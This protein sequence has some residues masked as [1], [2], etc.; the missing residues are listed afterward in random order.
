[1]IFCL[2][3][4]AYAENPHSLLQVFYGEA[5]PLP[6]EGGIN[7]VRSVESFNKGWRFFLGDEQSAK[8][9]EYNDTKWRVLTLPHDWSIEGE[10]SKD[11]PATH[12]GGALPGGVGWYR[13]TFSLP[14]LYNDKLVFI[15]FDGVYRNSEVWINGHYLGLRPYGYSSFRYDITPYLKFGSEKNVIAVRADNSEQPNSRWY[16]GSGIYRNVWLVITNK[17]YVDH[18]GTFIATPEVT[19]ERAVV[20]IEVKVRNDLS[21]ERQLIIKTIILD[22]EGKKIAEVKSDCSAA[23]QSVST[24]T[25]N[26]EIENP[27]LWSTDIPYLY[28]AVTIIED[29]NKVYDNYETA[30]GV[31]TF[32]FNSTRGFFLNGK[33]LKIYGVCNH[34]D[35]GCLGAAVNTRAIERQLEIL[36][37]MGCNGIRTSHNLPAPE[38][39]DLCDKMGFIVMDEAFDMW[40]KKKTDYDYSQNWDEWH[41]RDLQDLILRDRNHPSVFLWSIGNEILEQWDSTGIAIAQELAAIVKDLDNTRPITSGSNEPKPH[42]FIIRSGVNDVIGFNYHQEDFPDLLK[43]Y[44]GQKFIASETTSALASRGEYNMPSDS[45]RVWPIRWDSVFTQGN[46]DNTCSAYDNCRVPWG[47][48]HEEAWRLIKSY[49][50]L[51]GMFIWTGFDYL[52]EP[53]PYV[54]PSRSSYFGIIDLAG[55]PKDAYYMYQSEWTDKNVLHILPHWNWNKGDTIDVWAYTNCE[56]VELFLN[57]KSMGSKKKSKDDMHLTWRVPYSSGKVKA[58]GKKGKEILTYEIKTAGAA[59]NILL[60]ADRKEISADGKDLSFITV[61]VVDKEGNLVPKAD[62]LIEF[63]I[64]GMGSIVGV[65]NGLQT[66]HEPFKANYRKT[67]NGLCLVVIQSAEEHGKITLKAKSGG[68]G[69]TTITVETK[70]EEDQASFI[71]K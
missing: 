49:D 44:P 41:R 31:R 6:E 23:M 21:E 26:L 3:G 1:M 10:F 29:D 8:E 39:L 34:H 47:S 68:L 32:E 17:I 67:F 56:E 35:L 40:K 46:P 65:D 28:Q 12:N 48:T 59:A 50:F 30:F 54:W 69:E 70:R 71:E 5:V 63:E 27:Q 9:K 24:L 36:K 38:L 22:Q 19:K 64:I 11:N 51:S 18:W 53:T 37:E 66:S 45:I 4:L 58:I 60:E 33:P 13:K 15:D 20:S 42:N 62:N 2:Y 61:K 7:A 43:I 52:G 14:E 55:F 25:Q 57:D 16:S